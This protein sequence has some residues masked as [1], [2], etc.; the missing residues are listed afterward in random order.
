MSWSISVG[1]RR[2]AGMLHRERRRRAVLEA[3][4]HLDV[5]AGSR[6][7]RPRRACRGGR[8]TATITSSASLWPCSVSVRGNS[9][10]SISASRSSRLNVAIWS[11]R[12]VNRRLRPVT[13]PPMCTIAPSA[14]V[15]EL[16][17]RLLDLAAQRRLLA[18]QRVVGHVQ[19]EHLL[20]GAE[21]FG[22]VELDCREP[23]A[24]SS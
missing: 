22:L 14:Q 3:G 16:A 2:T 13:T 23:A 9:V 7:T 10:T 8:C 5:L 21:Q 6:P 12:L 4:E 11:P 1:P 15:L 20:L 17:D 19:A 18:E 24:R